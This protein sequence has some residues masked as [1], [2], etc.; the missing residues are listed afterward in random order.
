MKH[1]QITVGI[2]PEIDFDFK[3]KL[4]EKQTQQV[5]DDMEEAWN[6]IDKEIDPSFEYI[7][8]RKKH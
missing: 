3:A 6:A 8:P 5:N 7:P 1:Q 4:D 2:G